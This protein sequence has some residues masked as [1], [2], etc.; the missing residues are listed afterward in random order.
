VGD[1]SGDGDPSGATVGIGVGLGTRL[2]CGVGV[3]CGSTIDVARLLFDEPNASKPIEPQAK[4]PAITKAN[5]D[6]I[7]VP[8]SEY[9]CVT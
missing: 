6:F 5:L 3:S 9:E 4:I 7:Q 8:P 1:P 2:T